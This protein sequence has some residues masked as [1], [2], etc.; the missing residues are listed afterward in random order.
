MTFNPSKCCVMTFGR[1][2]HPIAFEYTING[3]VIIRST[4]VKD[5][6]VV[7]DRKLTFHD[8]ITTVAKD[9]FRRLGFVLR[10]ARDFQNAHVV[11]LL[12]S[13][14]VR[15]KLESSSCVWNPYEAKYVLLLEKVQ[16]AFLR[17]LYKFRF[18]YYP[19]LYPTKFLV[20]HLGCNMLQTRRAYDQLSIMLKI[21][22]GTTDA[23]DHTMS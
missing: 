8:H 7:F 22:R 3:T 6:G 13:T 9:S 20:G 14:L 11:Q 21:C 1:M 10:N 5:L 15:S 19:Y 2:Q 18:G 12:Y 17:F 16:K 4:T 23:P